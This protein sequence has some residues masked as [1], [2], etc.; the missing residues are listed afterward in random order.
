MVTAMSIG[1]HKPPSSSPW[2]SSLIPA[3]RGGS[4][5]ASSAASPP[6]RRDVRRS[7]PTAAVAAA[8][9]A[10]G[11]ASLAMAASAQALPVDAP[12]LAFAALQEPENALSLPT[13][14]IHVSSVIE[15]VTAMALVWQYGEKSG[16]QTWKGLTWGMVPPLG[17]ALC[18]C[19]WH[20]FYNAE[21]L[22][23]L[24]ALQ[25]ALTVLGNM[26][27]CFA[28]FRIYKASQEG[29]KSS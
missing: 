6:T 1:Y 23:V 11:T 22:E 24:V 18:A 3:P 21:S 2:S 20:F 15:W 12:V 14:A 8:L 5:S 19:T 7:L 10:C 28:A 4:S 9:V 25:S 27:M 16:F 13:W 26:T 17:G 29:S